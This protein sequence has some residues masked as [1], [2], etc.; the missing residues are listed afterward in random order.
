[1]TS[2]LRLMNNESGATAVEYALMIA[3]L[4][5]AVSAIMPILANS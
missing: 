4:G 2:I 5:L 1:M 3:A